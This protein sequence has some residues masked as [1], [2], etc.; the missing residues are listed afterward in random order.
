[1]RAP[2]WGGRRTSLG[3]AFSPAHNS[4]NFLRLVLALAVVVS[5]AILL[6]GFGS[7]ELF[8]RPTSLGMVAVYG[9]FGISGFLIASSASRNT[10]GHYLWQRCLRILPGFWVCLVVTAFG[11]ALVASWTSR[12]SAHCRAGLL[13]L[14][15][16]RPWL[17]RAAQLLP[18]DA[19]A[20]DLAHAPEHPPD[21]GVERLVVEPVLRVPVLPHD[22]GAGRRRPAR[23]RGVVALMGLGLWVVEAVRTAV[24]HVFGNFSV[25]AIYR[26]D[27]DTDFN[28]MAMKLLT[29]TPI[30]L[31]GTLLYLYR[32]RVPDS[33]LLALG[34]GGLFAASLWMPFGGHVNFF[35]MT[36]A[37]LF[38]P[39]LAYP[40][41]W[42][43]SPPA[44]AA[45]ASAP[46]T[47]TPTACYIL[48]LC[49]GPAAPGHVA[50][51][52]ALATRPTSA[53]RWRAWPLSPPPAG[54]WWRS[55]PSSSSASTSGHGGGPAGRVERPVR[56]GRGVAHAPLR[57]ARM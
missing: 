30:F 29:L 5:H 16:G 51:P 15:P 6:G 54:G 13:R 53:C 50:R 17:V 27:Y 55:G 4:L 33:G 7:H 20:P 12:V 11:I 47:T 2:A 26:F 3:D 35:S 41:L 40:L 19:A 32:D 39:F 31:A 48:R 37:D 24:P 52:S 38:A 9:F 44:P 14:R 49:N 21:S 22:R 43:R 10:F 28:F 1:M 57:I 42:P 45:T 34:C 18:V 36:S 46:A 8:H 25:Y 56:E 23:R